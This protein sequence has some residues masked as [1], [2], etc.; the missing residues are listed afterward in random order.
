MITIFQSTVYRRHEYPRVVHESLT[1]IFSDILSQR[2][3]KSYN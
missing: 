1:E 3:N 2:E